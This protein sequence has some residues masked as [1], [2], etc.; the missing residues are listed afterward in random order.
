VT[1]RARTVAGGIVV[2][3][4]YLTAALW[5]TGHLPVRPVFD[6]L[7]PPQPYRWVSP[8]PDVA[9]GNQAP[10]PITQKLGLKRDGTDEISV[11][12]PDGQATLI[13]PQ[14]AFLQTSNDRD[15][16]IDITPRDPMKYGNPPSRLAYSGNAY[17]MRATYEPSGNPASPAL[18][19]TILLSYPT[20]ASTLVLRTDGGWR[21]LAATDVAASLQLFAK[22]KDLGVFVAAGPAIANSLRWWTLGIASSIAALLGLG[23]GLRERRRL[24]R[25]GR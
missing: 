10:A 13:L 22:T 5:T 7:A 20:N 1:L 25:G 14:H 6:G 19:V 12:T 8:P 3:V 18:S 16:R 21:K 15:V 17:D 9:N 11:A 2:V 23:F 4:A 24:G